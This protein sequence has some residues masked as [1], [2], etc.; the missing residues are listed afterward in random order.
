MPRADLNTI[1]ITLI[2]IIMIF[3]ICFLAFC[4]CCR[5]LGDALY[6]PETTILSE[7]SEEGT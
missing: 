3:T 6:E 2:M 7:I 5:H 4:R 1:L